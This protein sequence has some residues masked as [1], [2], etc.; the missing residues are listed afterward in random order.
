[1]AKRSINSGLCVKIWEAK[2]E[3]M[4]LSRGEE[5]VTAKCIETKF[6]RESLES[7]S[8]AYCARRTRLLSETA[9]HVLTEIS[10]GYS[11]FFFNCGYLLFFSI[12]DKSTS[13]SDND[14]NLLTSRECKKRRRD[15]E[16]TVN[17]HEVPVCVPWF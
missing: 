11:F 3:D 5:R 12:L 13:R 6:S 8:G 9:S 15:E 17:T 4:P 14:G 16:V 10:P 1:M 2:R 7:Q